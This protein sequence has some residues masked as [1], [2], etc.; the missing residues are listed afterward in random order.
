MS[1]G[2]VVF[3]TGLF[4]VPIAL[5]VSGNRIRRR[6]KRARRVFWGAVIGHCVAACVALGFGLFPPEAWTADDALRG[7]GGFG[8]LLAFP[9]VGAALGM[10]G[11]RRTSS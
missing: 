10:T 1:A 5:L 6:S 4:G 3:L 11:G 7:L 2:M 9:V 8:S